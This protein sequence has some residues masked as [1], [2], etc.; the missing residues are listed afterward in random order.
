MENESSPKLADDLLYGAAAIAAEL[1]LRKHQAIWRLNHG[2][3]PARRL[4]R[5]WVAS[6]AALRAHMTAAT[7]MQET[8][9]AS[10]A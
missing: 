7:L 9:R 6:R 3:L 8:E 5:V 10:A 4:G 1:G 2:Q